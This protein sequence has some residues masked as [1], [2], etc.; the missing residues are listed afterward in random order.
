MIIGVGLLLLHGAASA[1][2]RDDSRGRSISSTRE[3]HVRNREMLT[4]VGLFMAQW[5]SK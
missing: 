2:E 1:R 4:R 3:E 5:W